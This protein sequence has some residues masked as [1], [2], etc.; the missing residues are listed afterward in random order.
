MGNEDIG[1]P[2]SGF[3]R[4]GLPNVPGNH[5]SQPEN[6]HL[7]IVNEIKSTLQGKTIDRSKVDEH[8]A[9][10]LSTMSTLELE[11]TLKSLPKSE[12]ERDPDFALALAEDYEARL[13]QED[14][15]GSEDY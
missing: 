13:H 15:D 2:R 7:N 5:V 12:W 11:R 14:R 9:K 10:V 3:D 6:P 8:R 4:T 1:K